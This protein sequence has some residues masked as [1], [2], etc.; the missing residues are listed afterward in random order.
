[1]S[2]NTILPKK[3]GRKSKKEL[4]ELKKLKENEPEVINTVKVHKKR[5]RKPKGGKIITSNNVLN[6][7]NINEDSFINA[8]VKKIESA[9]TN[10]SIRVVGMDSLQ[11]R[12]R[13]N[14][15]DGVNQAKIDFNYN[16]K[17]QWTRVEEVGGVGVSNGLLE[18]IRELNF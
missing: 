15:C 12:L 17:Q 14:F 9:I 7:S 13:I 2:E 3:R 4:E 8:F 1:M 16:S 10:T 11:Y 18:R 5:G 6:N